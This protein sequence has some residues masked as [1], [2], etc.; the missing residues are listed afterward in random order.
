MDSWTK[1]VDGACAVL[2]LR[3]KKQFETPVGRQLFY[4]VRVQVV[5]L[6]SYGFTSS[7]I[8]MVLVDQLY[9]AARPSPTT[10]FGVV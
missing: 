6:S 1:H 5:R 7:L 3:G 8:D 10:Y 9:S 2:N 4:S